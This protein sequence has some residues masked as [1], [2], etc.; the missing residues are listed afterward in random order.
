MPRFSRDLA[1]RLVLERASFRAVVRGINVAC[2]RAALRSIEDQ[3]SY[4]LAD[5][6]RNLEQ[7]LENSVPRMLPRERPLSSCALSIRG[8]NVVHGRT[9][10]RRP[11]SPAKS[12]PS[13][14]PLRRPSKTSRNVLPRNGV[15]EEWDYWIRSTIRRHC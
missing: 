13:R 14:I 12:F 8:L 6:L 5:G 10:K 9:V 3:R 7:L 11:C 15:E 2:D 4:A 1:V